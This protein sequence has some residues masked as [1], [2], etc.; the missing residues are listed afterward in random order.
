MAHLFATT[1]LEKNYRV[2]LN[3][4][5]LDNRPQVKTLKMIL[6]EWIIFRRERCVAVC[7]IAR[8]GAGPPAHP[9]KACWSPIST[10]TR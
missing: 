7:N 2:N 10:S 4:L 9:S 3:I 5:G 6:S 1:D 8:Q